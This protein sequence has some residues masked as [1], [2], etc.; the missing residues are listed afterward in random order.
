MRDPH[1]RWCGR[2]RGDPALYP[3]DLDKQPLQHA[4]EVEQYLGGLKPEHTV[5]AALQPR[6]SNSILGVAIAVKLPVN[7]DDQLGLGTVEVDHVAL[8]GDLPPK[9]VPQTASSDL[10]PEQS[11]GQG[12]I[13]A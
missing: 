4:V 7:L 9:S 5:S 6:G 1:V 8:H 12:H 10:A 13:A 11:L 3:M 2:G